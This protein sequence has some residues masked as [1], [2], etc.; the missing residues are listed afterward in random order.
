MF[1]RAPLAK[2]SSAPKVPSAT[3]PAHSYF[4]QSEALG[5]SAPQITYSLAAIR[6]F[7]EGE[8][9]GDSL[10]HLANKRLPFPL[11]AK[12]KVGAIND[13]LET[14]AD[15]VAELVMRMPEPHAPSHSNNLKSAASVANLT[16]RAAGCLQRKCDC[17]G[18][19][20]DC[21]IKDED[22]QHAKVQMK[23]TWPAITGGFEA[24]PIV[25]EVLRSPGRP[26][27]AVARA[28]MEPRFGHDFSKVRVHTDA[29]AAESARAVGARAYTVGSNV[30]F[31]AGEFAPG[32]RRGQ[33]LL[34]HELTHVVQQVTNVLARNPNKTALEEA[35]KTGETIVGDV[36]D[37][38]KVI[39]K[40]LSTPDSRLYS[41]IKDKFKSGRA[42]KTKYKI[43]SLP[44]FAYAYRQYAKKRNHPIDASAK[45]ED[46][47]RE[48]KGFYDPSSDVVFLQD[49]SDFCDAFHET[50]HSL[51]A[52]DF[53]LIWV[54][55]DL[56]E[57]LTQFFTDVVINEQ[58]S[59]V[60]H[61]HKYGSQAQ[62]AK[63]LAGSD[64]GIGFDA[65][66]RLFFFS[67]IRQVEAVAKKLGLN[68]I[69][70]L[71]TL[72]KSNGICKKL[73][74]SVKHGD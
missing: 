17:G 6:T 14:E 43:L 19:C 69:N 15:R 26:L 28:F 33:R 37:T 31:G 21:K 20:D 7:A 50:I 27:D 60:C 45:D 55:D 48:I 24:P 53:L 4:S 56:M 12:L 22:A 13:P 57:G 59:D 2:Q 40:T 73:G 66:A 1:S 63:M 5:W 36:S 70:E 68:N 18:T 61:R 62:C 52:P 46:V 30:V 35:G 8:H 44:E 11:Q 49:R 54:G 51:S 58:L 47:V 64:A 10:H 16:G 38:K 23:A 3:K 34:G 71:H 9:H 65:V 72:A 39:Q 74:V 41:Y 67:E 29:T 25:H 32:S 42:A